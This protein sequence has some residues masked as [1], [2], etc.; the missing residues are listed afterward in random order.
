MSVSE[1]ENLPSEEVR[2]WIE[3]FDRYPPGWREDSRFALLIQY[4][5]SIVG[6]RVRP[7]ELFGSLKQ[8]R[9]AERRELIKRGKQNKPDFSGFIHSIMSMKK[10]EDSDD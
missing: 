6:G 5:A 3:Y 9:D 8:M 4:I 1:V 7:E 2:G 10:R